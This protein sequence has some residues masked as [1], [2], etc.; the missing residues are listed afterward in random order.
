LPLK[1]HHEPP[2]KADLEPPAKDLWR[3]TP[4][5]YLGYT[6]ECGEAFA[7]YLPPFGVPATYAVAAAYVLADTVDK[8]LRAY[9]LGGVLQVGPRMRVA[10]ATCVETL[11]WQLCASV[12]WPGSLIRVVVASASLAV[13]AAHPLLA[14]AR[15][16][17]EI[18][19]ALP[20]LVGLAAIPFVVAPIDEA[21]SV[22]M[23]RSVAPAVHGKLQTLEEWATASGC[24]AVACALPPALFEL[25]A[26]L[27]AKDGSRV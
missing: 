15:V 17:S 3:D 6:N 2:L 21:V 7:V 14:E 1:H 8:T 13:A 12:F 11:S 23:E 27:R 19:R 18:E 4:L 25:A 16:P 24:L 9:H 20:T 10:A 5:R 22:L 26:V